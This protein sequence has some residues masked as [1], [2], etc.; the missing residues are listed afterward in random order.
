MSDA[1]K[2]EP[3]V[4]AQAFAPVTEMPKGLEPTAEE[5]KA[6]DAQA[7]ETAKRERLAAKAEAARFVRVKAED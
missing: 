7:E 3:V 1:K 5:R 2:Q 4:S 6:L